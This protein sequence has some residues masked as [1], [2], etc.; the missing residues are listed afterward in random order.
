LARFPSPGLE[1]IWPQPGTITHGSTTSTKQTKTQKEETE[2]IHL[3]YLRARIS[4]LLELSLWVSD[5]SG[6]HDGESVG[7][8]V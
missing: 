6:V 5:M 1:F 7:H 4:V 3:P 2:E 8:D